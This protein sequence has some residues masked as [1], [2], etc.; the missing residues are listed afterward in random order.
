VL[1]VGTS[2]LVFGGSVT[3]STT[4][5]LETTEFELVDPASYTIKYVSE[6]SI[7][8][9]T[10]DR[11]YALGETGTRYP[12]FDGEQQLTANGTGYNRSIETSDVVFDKST[13]AQIDASYGD[14]IT[15]V[16]ERN[17]GNSYT[18]GTVDI[19]PRETLGGR[20][21]SAGS[22]TVTNSSNIENTVDLGT[23]STTDNS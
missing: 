17:N 23:V 16:V 19:P 10:V 15:F 7:T 4:Q 11:I 9:S 3:S 18:A 22:V 12:I 1:S 8:G 5:Q 14:T 21:K 13:A 6:R 20:A 2:A